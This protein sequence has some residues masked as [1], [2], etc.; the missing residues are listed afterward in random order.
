MVAVVTRHP[1]YPAPTWKLVGP[2][3]RWSRPGHPEDGRLS[4]PAIQK[5]AGDDFIPGFLAHPQ[6]SLKYDAVIDVVNNFDLVTATSSMA[7]KLSSFLRLN[8]KGVPSQ[9][10]P[11]YRARLAPSA[12]RKLYQ[13]THD[14]HYVVTCQLHCDEPGFP[15]VKRQRVCQTGF[16][17]RRRRSVL[18]TG[19]SPETVA[20][21]AKPVQAKE[22]DLLELLAL[23][24]AASDPQAS[25][26]QKAN[27]AKQQQVEAQKAGVADWSALLAKRRDDL[28]AA[29]IALQKWYDDNGIATRIEGW[30]PTVND[31]KPSKTYGAW[32]EL[33]AAKQVADVSS[34][35]QT[36]PLFP[37]IPDPR[38]NEHDAAGRTMYYGVVQ[39]ASLQHDASGVPRFDDL[40]TYEVRCFV[41]EHQPAPARVGKMPDCCGPLAW[42]L[43]T[44]AF[45][46]A[47]PFDVLGAAN[48]P[49]TIK[50]PDL[51]ELAAQ[52]AMRPRGKLSPIRFVQPQHLSPKI[53]DNAAEGGSMGGE[54]ICS[55]S[56]PLITII[57]MF[58]LSLFL[59]IVVFI[60]NLWFLLV[61]RFC[62][63]PQVSFGAGLDAALAVTPPKVDLDADFSVT[64]DT[65]NLDVIATQ[66][67][68][69]LTK[70]NPNQAGSMEQRI[71]DA[72]GISDIPAFENYSNNALGPIDQSFADAATFKPDAAGNLPPPPPVGSPLEY[73]AP[74]TPVWPAKGAP[75]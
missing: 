59:P 32:V 29:R 24:A 42:S 1:V 10:G 4:R 31:G 15:R 27:A 65:G 58:V 18:P 17:L 36:Y 67:A 38:E 63:P 6:H 21:Q 70:D 62:I 57:A 50:M 26:L 14:R 54:A 35:E 19:M 41:R 25:A 71:M 43:P 7:G 60:F 47:A 55:F 46:V 51:R 23:D 75:A 44:E 8:A 22:A 11:F 56:I 45:R 16:V 39:T 20:A 5:F 69:L 2:W 13:P 28:E 3:Y 72:N 53:K 66:L 12:L 61:F 52:A 49:I 64:V 68:T 30:F 48:R 74:V 9:S 40:S 33:D 34:G 73:E 37:L